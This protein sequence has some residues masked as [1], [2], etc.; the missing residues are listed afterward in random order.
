[1]T[2]LWLSVYLP[3]LKFSTKVN[4]M[5]VG[6]WSLVADKRQGFVG[7]LQDR[8]KSDQI[9][10]S[11]AKYSTFSANP[12]M[13]RSHSANLPTSMIWTSL[14]YRRDKWCSNNWEWKISERT[15]TSEDAWAA[16]RWVACCSLM[17]GEWVDGWMDGWMDGWSEQNEQH[18]QNEQFYKFN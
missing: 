1:M 16:W 5:K 9:E 4:D 2:T 17:N 18:E 3:S 12:Q 11:P 13:L 6:G 14:F 15:K 7:N 8:V 10:A